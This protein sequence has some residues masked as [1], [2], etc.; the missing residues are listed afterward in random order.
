[1]EICR[2]ENYETPEERRERALVDISSSIGKIEQHNSLQLTAKA[3]LIL[4]Q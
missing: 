1:M 2:N 3:V 4:P